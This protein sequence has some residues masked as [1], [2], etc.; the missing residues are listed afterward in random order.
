MKLKLVFL[1]AVLLFSATAFSQVEPYALGADIS[2]IPQRESETVKYA[3]NGQAKDPVVI[4]KEQGFNYIRLRLFVDP[5]A[6][7]PGQTCDGSWCPSPYSAKGFCGLEST[8]AMAKR[9]KAAGMK[10]LLDFHYSDT[11]ADPGKQYKPVAWNSLNSTQLIEKVRTYT[12]ETLEEFKKNGVLPDMVQ[13]GNEVINGMIHPDG[14]GNTVAFARLVNAGI[15]GAKEVDPNIKIMMHTTSEKN[16]NNWLTTLKNNLNSVEAG[17]ADKIDVIGLSYYPKWHGD[18]NTL[19]QILN[20]I[21]NN[22]NHNAIKIAVVEYADKHREVNDLVFNLPQNKGFGTFVWEPEEF[23]GDESLPLFD[24]KNNRRESNAL[25]ALYPQM[26]LDFLSQSNSEPNPNT[27]P[28]RQMEYLDRGLVAVKISGGVY[29][30]WRYLGTD[31]P[32]VGFN[33]Y[34]NGTKINASPITASTNYTDAQGTN[35]STYTVKA[36]LNGVEQNESKSVSV[37]AQ[38]YKVLNLRRPAGGTNPSGSYTYTPNDCSVGDVDGDG[39]YEIIVKWDPSD[40]QDNSKPGYTGNVYLDCYKLDG[41]FLWRIDLGKNIR[42]GAHYTQFMVYDLDG[43][44]KAEVVCKTAPGTIDG[45]GK[46]VLMGSDS[47]TADYRNSDGYVLSGPEYLTIFNGLTGAEIH[48]IAYNPPRGTVTSWGDDYGN[49]VDRF[50]ACVAYLDGVHPSVVMCRGYY[51]RSVLVAYDFKNGKLEQRWIHNSA[52]SGQ[53]AYSEGFHNVS[54]ADVDNDGFDE[55]IYG[56]AVIDHDGKLLYRK[57]YG[58]GDAMHISDLDP[59]RPGLEGWFVH[60]DKASAYG[61]ELRDLKTGQVIFGE[62]TGTDVGRGL[63]ADIDP[64]HPGFEMWSAASNDVYNCKGQVISTNKPSTN[65]RIYWDGDLQDELLDG[66]K[67]DKWNGNGTSRLFTAYN[68]ANAKEINGTKANPC[69]SADILGDWREEMIFYDWDD[70]SKIVIFTTTI[71]TTHRLFTLMHD[72][73]YRMCVA[74]QNVAYNQPPHLGFYI[75]DGLANVS[76]PNI[77]VVNANAVAPPCLSTVDL[78]LTFSNIEEHSVTVHWSAPINSTCIAGY[79]VSINGTLYQTVTVPNITI[80]ALTAN[81]E[82][83]ISVVAV[84]KAGNKSEASTG[85]T[86]TLFVDREAPTKPGTLVIANI[87]ETSCTVTWAASTDNVAVTGYQVSVNGILRTTVTTL[88]AA[89]SGLT[90]NTEYTISIVAI[91]AAGNRSDASAGTVKTLFVDREA[92]S[93]PGTLSF[94]NIEETSCTVTWAASTDN[95]A[96]TGYEVWID[97]ALYKTVTGAIIDIEGLTANTTYAVSVIAYDAAGNK[98][99]ASAGTFKTEKVTNPTLTQTIELSAGWNLISIYVVPEN[100]A[101][102]EIFAPIMAQID[103][104]KNADG[105]YKPGI[106]APLQSLTEMQAGYGYLVKAKTAVTLQ[107]EGKIAENVSVPVKQGWNMIG[108]PFEQSQATTAA[109]SSVWANT[110]IIQN[111]DGFLDKTS[112]TLNTMQAGKGYYIYVAN[113]GVVSF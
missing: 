30:S 106:P 48:T 50:L 87:T 81:T 57:G 17:A 60:E 84:D 73:V 61:F 107:V 14:S 97:G 1:L 80:S 20:S 29:L 40:A 71:V 16:P 65:F 66:T 96:V 34:R 82:Y 19:T 89:I 21:A 104:V 2:W 92:P 99:E 108:Y 36:V 90:A 78:Q 18:L 101:I 28:P 45:K 35:S 69:L 86:K 22:A 54:V 70:P 74:W 75:G 24:W 52:T 79:E 98:S 46:N 102:E 103:I 113:A 68:F 62:K 110:E 100:A 5:T 13:I 27:A 85:I 83:S 94:S 32:A 76:Q 49:R 3:H 44:G 4:F 23:S 8:I 109:L 26:A 91:D 25:F 42:A 6:T 55:I 59:S 7:I 15:K 58:H 111:F 88:G 56:S 51:T 105:F 63:A 72:P 33:L 9:V 37:W 95:A 41:T 53:G 43:D 10:L 93:K 47:P 11:W 112:G 12:K 64:K 31:S 77:Y 67:V 39:E 38:Q